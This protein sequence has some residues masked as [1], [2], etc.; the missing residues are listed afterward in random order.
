MR[1]PYMSRLIAKL[2][3]GMIRNYFHD[4]NEFYAGDHGRFERMVGAGGKS[5]ETAS[6]AGWAL[7]IRNLQP[8]CEGYHDDELSAIHAQL[9]EWDILAYINRGEPANG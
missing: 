7:H 8:E 5:F 3:M 4:L 9:A 2:C 6:P 1:T